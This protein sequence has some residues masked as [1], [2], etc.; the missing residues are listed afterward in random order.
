[1]FAI[2][3]AAGQLCPNLDE[4]GRCSIH[5]SRAREGYQGCVDFD[6]FGAG[7]RVTQQFFGGLSCIDDP[8]LREPM[9]R[10]F[11][12]VLRAHECLSLLDRARNLDLAPSDR[13]LLDALSAGIEVAGLCEKSLQA[14][15]REALEFLRTLRVY[16]RSYSASSD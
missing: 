3:K 11:A 9:S 6:C 16:V 13:R 8:S 4:C 15:R 7:Q 10:A 5:A 1:M 12:T 14:S 2:D